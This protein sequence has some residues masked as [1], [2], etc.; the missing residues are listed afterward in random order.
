MAAAE[1]VEVEPSLAAEHGAVGQRTPVGR[2]RAGK[3]RRERFA[4]QE[5]LV[6]VQ[7]A[8]IVGFGEAEAPVLVEVIQRVGKL[9]QVVAGLGD[10]AVAAGG[11]RV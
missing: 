1:K 8:L 9:L 6:G 2:A 5:A 3:R 10:G 7:D 11:A 4:D